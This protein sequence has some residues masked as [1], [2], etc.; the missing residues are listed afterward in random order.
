MLDL[1]SF[2]FALKRWQ[3]DIAN[4]IHNAPSNEP[5]VCRRN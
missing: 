4:F 5:R 2:E 1:H 3:L